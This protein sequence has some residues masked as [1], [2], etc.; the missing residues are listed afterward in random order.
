MPSEIAMGLFI[1][2]SKGHHFG[3]QIDITIQQIT[4]S[5]HSNHLIGPTSGVYRSRAAKPEC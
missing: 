5:Q 4:Y 2:H 1:F 3:G